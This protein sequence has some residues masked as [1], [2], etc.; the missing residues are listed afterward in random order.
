MK[1]EYT[2]AKH[3]GEP[4]EW[5]EPETMHQRKRDGNWCICSITE[6]H[7][8]EPTAIRVN[9]VITYDVREEAP[10][11]V[12][13]W[14]KCDGQD[15][16]GPGLA[17]DNCIRTGFPGSRL[18]LRTGFPGSRLPFT[19]EQAQKCADALGVKLRRW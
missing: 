18:P 11:E 2:T 10:P 9:D 5:I 14:F 13:L 6:P 4:E 17:L 15:Y 16:H 3:K 1:I 12:F 8:I 19:L 7:W